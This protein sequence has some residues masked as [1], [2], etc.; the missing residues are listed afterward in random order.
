MVVL[1]AGVQDQEE[2][3][4]LDRDHPRKL[5]LQRQLAA[6]STRGVQTVVANSGHWVPLQAP[7]SVIG[8]LRQIVEGFRSQQE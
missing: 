5:E 8:A 3:P 6:L 7:E 2:D 4:Q 1:S